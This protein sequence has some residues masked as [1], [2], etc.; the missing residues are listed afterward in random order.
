MAK[1]IPKPNSKAS[2]ENYFTYKK[3]KNDKNYTFHEY[4]VY[5]IYH[6]NF[7]ATYTVNDKKNFLDSYF[8]YI[9]KILKSSRNKLSDNEKQITAVYFEL[10]SEVSTN[11]KKTH[12]L[13]LLLVESCKKFGWVEF[14]PSN[15]VKTIAAI[16]N[17]QSW[18]SNEN[19]LLSAIGDYISKAPEKELL[20]DD[21]LYSGIIDTENIETQKPNLLATIQN[22][23]EWID[24][25]TISIPK[26]EM[27]ID[28]QT[29]RSWVEESE[30][31][32][33][34]CSKQIIYD[35]KR[36]WGNEY[37]QERSVLINEATFTHDIL[38][39]LLNFISPGY[40][41]RWDQ[42]QSISAKGRG[43]RKFGDTIGIIT[44]D[45]DQFETLF[46]EV[47]YG[48]FHH[49]PEHH[50]DEDN[51]KLGKLGKDSI[52]RIGKLL[53]TD[54]I[55]IIL[56]HFFQDE[57]SFYLMDK[58]FSPA[59]RKIPIGRVRIPLFKYETTPIL[60][61]TETFPSPV[62]AKRPS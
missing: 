14:D 46:V 60:Q 23:D 40:F 53:N 19:K 2:F 34:K 49:D 30:D 28:L 47:S 4:V 15:D 62:R 10:L 51:I 13:S 50:I 25:K 36:I 16:Q 45:G 61:D 59:Y 39:S 21:P 11:F 57:I 56:I 9:Q 54:E 7:T 24:V 55:P 5:N 35:L 52:D 41:K 58:E 3:D 26:K 22:L 27:P 38:P 44:R 18:S 32:I 33:E 6:G 20:I 42:A 12:Q 37:Y 43:A 31:E 17:I 29:I 48:P 1:R 8:D